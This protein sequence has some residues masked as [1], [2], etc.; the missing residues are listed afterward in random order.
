MVRAAAFKTGYFATNVDTQSYIFL[1]EVLNQD[2]SGLP[3]FSDWGHSSDPDWEIDQSIVSA[4]GAEN[5]KDDLKS[6]PTMSLVMDWDELFG[7][8][9]SG[10]GHGI[11]TQTDG[12]RDRSDERFAS[13]EYFTEGLT[14]EFQIDAVVEIQGHSS[15]QPLE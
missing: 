4:V 12:W 7:N 5:L 9:T 1:D 8:G 10:D 2:G 3:T 13:L 6:I 11:Y 15:A 14:E